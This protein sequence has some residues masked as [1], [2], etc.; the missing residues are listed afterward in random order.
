LILSS[1]AAASSASGMSAP[2]TAL[3]VLR[4]FQMMRSST[5]SSQCALRLLV[6]ESLFLKSASVWVLRSVMRS[7]LAWWLG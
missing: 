5:R 3:E 4:A 2:R 7:M 6:W 1:K